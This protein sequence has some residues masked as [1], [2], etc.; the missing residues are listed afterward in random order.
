[1]WFSVFVEATKAHLKLNNP[2]GW[3]AAVEYVWYQLRDE[4]KSQAGTCR[5]T[6]YFCFHDF[7]VC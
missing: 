7:Q 2:A 4:K 1:M 6:L 5:K 3:A